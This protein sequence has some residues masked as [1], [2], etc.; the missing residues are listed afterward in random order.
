MDNE[1]ILYSFCKLFI[2]FKF[3]NRVM[4]TVC[5]GVLSR[6]VRPV[7]VYVCAA[8]TIRSGSPTSKA[9]ARMGNARQVTSA[10][11]SVNTLNR[12]HTRH[13]LTEPQPTDLN[14][15]SCKTFLSSL[16]SATAPTPQ[17][18][19]NLHYP[20][21][22]LPPHPTINVTPNSPIVY[23]P[24]L[25]PHRHPHCPPPLPHANRLLIFRP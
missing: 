6:P 11:V 18:S 10:S 21:T 25:L 20:V 1:K 15:S 17:I 13:T 12:P 19:P 23:P 24:C 2:V 8:T 5:P 7:P 9:W 14:V 3:T 16:T 22:L 4:L